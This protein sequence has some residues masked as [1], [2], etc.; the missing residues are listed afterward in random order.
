MHGKR[1]TGPLVAL[2]LAGCDGLPAPDKLY[3]G[4]DLTI[5]DNTSSAFD[6]PSPPVE[7]SPD[8]LARW[9]NGDKLWSTDRVASSVDDPPP[10][11]TGGLGPLYVG[12]SCSNCH[13]G[14]GRTKP[15]LFTH[16]GTGFD[17]SSFLVFLRTPFDNTFREYGRVL[18]DH[19]VFG[20]KPEGRLQVKYTVVDDSRPVCW[21]A[22]G[23]CDTDDGHCEKW[24]RPPSAGNPMGYCLIREDPATCRSFPDGERYCLIRPHYRLKDLHA[25]DLPRDQMRISVRTPLRHLGLG[26]L[27]AV[28][29]D[30]IRALAAISYPS[31]GISGK[32]QWLFE[33]GRWAIGLSGHKATHA[34][35]TVELGFSSDL[36]VTSARFPEEV[37]QGQPQAGHDFGIEISTVDMADVDMYLRGSGVPARRNVDDPQVVRGERLFAEAACAA[38]HTPTLHTSP[39]IPRLLDGTPLPM[40][41]RQTIHPYSDFLLH[42][43]GP[44]LG[45]DYDQWEARGDEWRTAPLWGTG[46]QEIVSGHSHFL[47][48]G[49]ARDLQE[50]I[51]WHFG[52]EGRVSTELFLH[53]PKSDRDALIAFL[54]SL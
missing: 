50:A 4:G 1:H 6:R 16:G 14:G 20:V 28:D 39:E 37:A 31:Y 21:D 42:D 12:K 32:L 24:L 29:P 13:A 35:L 11:G 36:G 41:A 43:M 27:L 52:E 33:Q 9:M 7:R 54:R 26:L 48:D 53:M 2:L 44:D 18:H 49:R 5:F 46:L 34:D 51:L 23:V 22:D 38:C 3:Q 8:H 45:D 30:E 19:A 10:V 40:L 17:F 25:G 15:T 47:H